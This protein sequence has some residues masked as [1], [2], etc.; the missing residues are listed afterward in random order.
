M[1]MQVIDDV[2]LVYPA[3][4]L[5]YTQG[6][7]EKYLKKACE[8]LV[9]GRSHPAIFN[10]DIITKGLMSYGVPE[11][12]AHNYVHSTCVE[13]TPVAASNVWVASPYHN[14]AQL[15]LD[16]LDRDYNSFEE[17]L[18]AYFSHLDQS[19]KI[20]NDAQ[21]QIQKSRAKYSL[22]PLL[23]C[24]VNDCL[25]DGID[26]EKGGARYNWIM[27][28]FVGMG[29]LVDS[30]YAIKT[31]IF[32]KKELTFAQLKTALDNNFVG[33]E[34]LRQQLLYGVQK[35][36][37][38]DDDI[39]KYYGIITNHIISECKKYSGEHK[40]GNVVPSVFCWEMHM[41][42]GLDT[43][44]TPDG[45]VVGFPLGDGSGPCQGREHSGPTASIISSTKWD[46]HELIGGVA[47]NMKFS[48][49][50]L[51][52][53]SLDTMLS[54][55]KTYLVRGGF[56]IQINVLDASDLEKA[57]KNPELYR[58]LVVRVGGYSDYFT[59][60]TP[61]MQDEVILRTAHKI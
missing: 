61:Q 48:K 55:I 29:N 20:G 35:Y 14:L 40:N 5:C 60:L 27:P 51:G 43:G 44:A 57:K 53:Q 9:K 52:E 34:A 12:D 25:K 22:H 21:R 31:L 11:K 10:D 30:L 38:D 6:M 26:I 47:V 24:F 49:N 16:C 3:V 1:C 36:G 33:F 32:D 54:I 39:D 59:R 8:I 58:D 19:I 18:S 37:N 46:H 17:L 56:E 15:L 28:S 41:R 42:F 7:N 45:R 2:S 50:S 13:I 4:G 23:S